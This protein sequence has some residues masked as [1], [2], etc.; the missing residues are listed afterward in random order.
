MAARID[1]LQAIMTPCYPPPHQPAPSFVHLIQRMVKAHYHCSPL[2]LEWQYVSVMLHC[3]MLARS[4]FLQ[5]PHRECALHVALRLGHLEASK[6]LLQAPSFDV[7][8]CDAFQKA[9]VRW[10]PRY[11]A[12]VLS[13]RRVQRRANWVSGILR[14]ALNSHATCVQPKRRRG[15][16]RHWRPMHP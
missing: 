12:P 2:C 14:H 16:R 5:T 1:L 13:P 4:L 11:C 15:F 7:V 8:R 9:K 10:P 3:L 6:M